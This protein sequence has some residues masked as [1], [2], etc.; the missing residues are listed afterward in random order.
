VPL[1]LRWEADAWE[2]EAKTIPYGTNS[3]AGI[4]AVGMLVSVTWS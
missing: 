4:E 2:D 1:M 3:N